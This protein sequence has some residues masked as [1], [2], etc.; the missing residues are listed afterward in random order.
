MKVSLISHRHLNPEKYQEWLLRCTEVPIYAQSW[1]LNAVAPTWH[2]LIIDDGDFIM[3]LPVNQ[4]YWP[5][6]QVYQPYFCQQLGLFSPENNVMSEVHFDHIAR[7]LKNKFLKLH[8]TFHEA[9]KWADDLGVHFTIKTNQVLT[10]DATYEILRRGYSDNLKRNLKKADANDLQLDHEIGPDEF[11]QLFHTNL[12]S[13]IPGWSNRQMMVLKRLMRAAL[14]QDVATS[15]LARN[16]NAE[17]EAGL[18]AVRFNDR[19][20]LLAPFSTDTGKVHGAMSFIIDQVIRQNAGSNVTL[21]FEGSDVPGIHRFNASFGATDRSCMTWT[22]DR[23][24]WT[25][26]LAHSVLR[27]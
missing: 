9:T 7:I 26:R 24:P 8:Y 23:R 1:Y 10:L 19:I 22:F 5:F 15:Y 6:Y 20:T 3:P 4:K 12:R 25:Y 18:F 11:A 16:Q 21:D 27:R 14:D 17:L 2:V 13:N